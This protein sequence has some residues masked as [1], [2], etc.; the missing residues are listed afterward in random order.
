MIGE[1]NYDKNKRGRQTNVKLRQLCWKP[2]EQ[3]NYII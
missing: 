3:W 1:I 2:L